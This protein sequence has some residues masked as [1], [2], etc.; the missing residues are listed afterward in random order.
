MY[1]YIDICLHIRL[2]K[3]SDVG[4]LLSIFTN[5]NFFNRIQLYYMMTTILFR[6]FLNLRY[7]INKV[8]MTLNL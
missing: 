3:T 2:R 1:R 8:Y 6:D 4:L 5:V 7:P